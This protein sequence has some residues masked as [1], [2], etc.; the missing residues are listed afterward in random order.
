MNPFEYV[1]EF[2]KQVAAYAG[3]TYGIAT[4]C[5][6]HAIFLSAVYHRL[7][8]ISPDTVVIPKNT[9]VSV[10][11]QLR[12][13]GFNVEFRDIKWEG[14]YTIEP[15]NIVDAAP[16]FRKGMYV[17][18]TYHCVSF[19]FK[20]ILSTIKGGMIL[21][22]DAEFYKWAQRATHD[23]RDMSV[24][25]EEDNINMLGYHMFMT[26]ETAQMGLEKMKTIPDFNKDIAGSY[27]YPD[28]SYT[29]GLK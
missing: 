20:K 13:A 17:P 8:R 16:R 23:G 22:D 12:H 3:A 21:T 18:G 15:T 29:N 19:Q 11:M 25:Y 4:D 2:E 1:H 6:S 9:Y 27:T 7:S 28:V 24:P 14:A 26:P 10:P 5:C